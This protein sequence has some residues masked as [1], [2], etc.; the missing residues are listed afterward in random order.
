MECVLLVDDEAG[1]TDATTSREEDPVLASRDQKEG[2]MEVSLELRVGNPGQRQIGSGPP[3][4]VSLIDEEPLTGLV[5][6][7]LPTVS[8]GERVRQTRRSHLEH[9]DGYSAGS[10]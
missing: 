9:H 7:D 8:P 5:S 10:G 1:L 6:C 2:G 3:S 4:V